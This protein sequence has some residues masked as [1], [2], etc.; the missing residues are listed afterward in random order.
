MMNQSQL[1]ELK[2]IV[3]TQPFR[4]PKA[5]EVLG[6]LLGEIEEVRATVLFQAARIAELS[7]ATTEPRPGGLVVA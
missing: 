7:G 4:D 1:D 2:R 5:R 6:F 3:E